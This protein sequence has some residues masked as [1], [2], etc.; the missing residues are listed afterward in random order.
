MEYGGLNNDPFELKQRKYTYSPGNFSPKT[1]HPENAVSMK[2]ALVF[3]M[4]TR[5]VEDARVRALVKRAHIRALK[6]KFIEKKKARIRNSTNLFEGERERAVDMAAAHE[7]VRSVVVL[8]AKS[9]FLYPI[10]GGPMSR[11]YSFANTPLKAAH[12][13]LAAARGIQGSL[14]G[15]AVDL[16]CEVRGT[17]S[18]MRGSAAGSMVGRVR[19]E[20]YTML[21]GYCVQRC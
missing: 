16:D 4:E 15:R 6:A 20:V 10:F 21:K 12:A 11:T 1:I 14:L 7:E 2:F 19:V 8:Y 5:V 17:A 13:P 18:G 9:V 3:M